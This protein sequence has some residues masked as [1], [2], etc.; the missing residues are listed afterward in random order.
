MLVI[1]AKS[2]ACLLVGNPAHT[3]EH[4]Q[5][6]LIAAH[7]N[8]LDCSIDNL[9]LAY[10][11]C[12]M[13]VHAVSVQGPSQSQ[14]SENNLVVIETYDRKHCHDLTQRCQIQSLREGLQESA[15]SLCEAH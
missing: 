6:P 4:E 10:N 1:E 8:V 13:S 14:S 7:T 12:Q 3:T 9:C 15:C 5:S 2:S 11:P